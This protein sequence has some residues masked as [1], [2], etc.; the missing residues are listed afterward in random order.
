MFVSISIYKYVSKKLLGGTKL[1][2]DFTCN[3]T[4]LQISPVKPVRILTLMHIMTKL[5]TGPQ[6]ETRSHPVEKGKMFSQI[7]DLKVTLKTSLPFC[8]L[9]PPSLT[10]STDFNAFF[11]HS[12]QTHVH[13]PRFL[14]RLSRLSSLSLTFPIA[15]Y[16]ALFDSVF[17]PL[18]RFVSF[19]LTP[20]TRI[21]ILAP[22][23]SLAISLLSLALSLAR[24]LYVVRFSPSSARSR[25]RAPIFARSEEHT[26]ELQSHA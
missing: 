24:F 21:L 13:A 19:T 2:K 26:S 3:E 1:K 17:H 12:H 20:R 16:Y 9:R 4:H 5:S 23:P 25:T 10:H 15:L 14:R 8:L 7:F 6:A 11:R 22:R 18:S